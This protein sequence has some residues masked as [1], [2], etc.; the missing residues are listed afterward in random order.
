M[1]QRKLALGLTAAILGFTATAYGAETLESVEKKI[2]D[3]F[4]KY[5]TLRLK[6]KST[7]EMQTDQI[8]MK[9][10]SESTSEY[11]RR[12][13]NKWASR[14]EA[15]MKTVRK[16]GD[17]KEEKEDSSMLSVYD[18]QFAY[19]LTEVPNYKSAVRSKPDPK[20]N[21]NPL[22]G[23][24]LLDLMHKDYN[25]KL[26]PDET[27]DGKDAYVIEATAKK[28][29]EAPGVPVRFVSWYEKKTGVA[30][31]TVTYDK[32][33]KAVST[34]I[35]TAVEPDADIPADRF[36]FK[37]PPGVKLADA[38]EPV[39]A[40]N[41]PTAKE[42]EQPKESPA[43]PKADEAKEQPTKEEPKKEEAK[44]KDSKKAIKGL[45]DKLK[46]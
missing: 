21:M 6:Q 25:C 7:S 26:L 5:K 18:G 2:A 33:G 45:F 28:P 8:K 42:Q 40:E 30:I 43:S 36:V 35:T 46:P 34:T 10:T 12:P 41:Q 31:K 13:A 29:S 32:A 1:T 38:A 24:A 16:V 17:Q 19:T 22:D 37:T 14:I 39:T 15:K 9:V 4:T 27:L 3:Q 44:P 23:K 20:H 11:A